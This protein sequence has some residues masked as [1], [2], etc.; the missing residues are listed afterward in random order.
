M[1]KKHRLSAE[2]LCA[3]T[4][5]D[6]ALFHDPKGRPVSLPV[7]SAPLADTHGHLTHFRSYDPAMALARAS[8]AG[9]RL[10]GGPVDP[11]DDAHDAL[12]LLSDIESWGQR[13]FTCVADTPS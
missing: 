11:T 9:V 6:G 13:A 1:S 8:L 7:A 5:E 12:A 10:L 3:L 4:R 2:E